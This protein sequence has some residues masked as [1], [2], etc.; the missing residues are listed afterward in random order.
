MDNTTFTPESADYPSAVKALQRVQR[1]VGITGAG[2]IGRCN[3]GGSNF[4]V[5]GLV[6][7]R[8]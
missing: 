8:A 2:L 1:P 5:G 6:Q 4:R 3:P 7:C